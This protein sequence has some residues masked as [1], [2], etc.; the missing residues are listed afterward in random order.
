M[1]KEKGFVMDGRDIGTVVLPD[2]EVK[3][4]LTAS[5]SARAMRRYLENQK[6]Y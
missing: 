5:A 3:I 4:Y 6:R 1:A 2:A